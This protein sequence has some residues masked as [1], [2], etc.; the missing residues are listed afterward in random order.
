MKVYVLLH[1]WDMDVI[2]E[3]AWIWAIYI[4]LYMYEYK[5]SENASNP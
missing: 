4:I 5:S 3:M 2:D 1:A